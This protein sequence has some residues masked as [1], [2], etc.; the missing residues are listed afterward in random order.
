M[1]EM[2]LFWSFACSGKTWWLC[3]CIVSFY[4]KQRLCL[5][6]LEAD[7]ELT[8][9]PKHFPNP[10]SNRHVHYAAELQIH[11][12][13]RQERGAD[14]T[15]AR[16]NRLSG[17][18]IRA[19]DLLKWPIFMETGASVSVHHCQ[20]LFRGRLFWELNTG[21]RRAH[22]T[23]ET[24]RHLVSLSVKGIKK[25]MFVVH[26]SMNLSYKLYLHTEKR[27]GLD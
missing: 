3:E 4:I 19:V 16:K 25:L 23:W 24:S 5:L 2:H 1:F 11:E 6:A 14:F 8:P 15:L 27:V 22:Q 18:M 26:F 7:K 13:S 21:H 9:V 17:K 10:G 20:L 12:S